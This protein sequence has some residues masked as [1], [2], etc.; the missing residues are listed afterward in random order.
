MGVKG[1]GQTGLRKD[2]KKRDGIGSA[3]LVYLVYETHVS[4]R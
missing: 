1:R 2:E 4:I 3:G